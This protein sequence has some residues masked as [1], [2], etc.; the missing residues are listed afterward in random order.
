MFLLGLHVGISIL[1][2]IEEIDKFSIEL[3]LDANE[4]ELSI[5]YVDIS[6]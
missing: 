2:S 5:V 4:E 1:V 6:K 3:I